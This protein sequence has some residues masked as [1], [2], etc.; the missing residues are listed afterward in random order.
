MANKEKHTTDY[1]IDFYWPIKDADPDLSTDGQ[2]QPLVCM[3]PGLRG[4]LKACQ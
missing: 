1:S 4:Y 2:A 3:V